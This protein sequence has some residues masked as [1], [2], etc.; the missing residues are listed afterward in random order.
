MKK[1]F[2]ITLTFSLGYLV[3]ALA[4][5]VRWGSLHPWQRVDFFSG[6]YLA[7]RFMGSIHSLVS[8][9]GVFAS[10]PVMREWWALESDHS[11]PLLV[12]FLMAADLAVFVD[13]GH[14]HLVPALEQPLLQSLGLGL[15]LAVAIWQTWTDTYLARYFSQ[16]SAKAVPMDHGPYLYV[17]H[18]RYSAAIVAKVAVALALASVL[19]WVLAA[20]WTIIM[21]RKIAIEEAHLRNVFGTRYKDYSQKT[22]KVLPGIY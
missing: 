5:L 9:R 21:L 20:A 2:W 7:L 16:E 3:L 17:R 6:G 4:S 11:A 19:G 8:S 12:V 15:Y 18:P 10:K 1:S 14:W 13:Y 22:A